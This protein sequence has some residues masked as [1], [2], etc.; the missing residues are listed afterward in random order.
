MVKHKKAKLKIFVFSGPGGAGKTT[1]V[2]RLFFK[3]FV[4]SNFVKGI[5]YTTRKKRRQ[6]KEG[7]DYLFVSK[8]TFL[9][10]R[11]KKRLLE[12]EKVL[13]HYYGTPLFLL[14]KAKKEKKDL[15]LCID[16]KGGMS[17]KNNLKQ[18]TI[19][20]IFISAPTRQDLYRRLEKRSEDEKLIENRIQLAKQELT[21]A[22][23]Y[24]Y[25]VVNYD[26]KTTVRILE[27]IL[28]SEKFRR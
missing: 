1:L 28:L 6:E 14:A 13:S 23:K 11:K 5:S 10:L 2:N 16:V 9:K 19:V 25:V 27:A 17:L 26:I 12:N 15:I 4:K 20:T 7:R 21:F 22:D 18:G 3:K 8:E 24:D